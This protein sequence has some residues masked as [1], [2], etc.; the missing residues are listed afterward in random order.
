[1]REYREQERRNKAD[2]AVVQAA[3][4]RV[5]AELR[6]GKWYVRRSMFAEPYPWVLRAPRTEPLASGDGRLWRIACQHNAGSAGLQ[7]AASI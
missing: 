6:K 4:R 7:T 3:Q 1:M 2:M 5:R